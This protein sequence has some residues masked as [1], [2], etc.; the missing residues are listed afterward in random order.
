[1]PVSRPRRIWVALLW[2]E[3]VLC[4]GPLV[5]MLVFGVLLLP[6]W[7]FSLIADVTGLLPHVQSAE[8]VWSGALSVAV[9]AC[10]VLGTGGL[11][12]ILHALTTG[13]TRLPRWQTLAMVTL[14]VIGATGFL[15]LQPID[16]REHPISFA[17]FYVLPFFGTVHLLFMARHVL[18][19]HQHA[20]S[21]VVPRA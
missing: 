12:V 21:T 4:F 10:G 3:A 8:S 1:M 7:I 6:I 16:A 11:I 5:S 2:I 14:G 19:G 17:M 13:T 18:S 15:L 9:V 20:S